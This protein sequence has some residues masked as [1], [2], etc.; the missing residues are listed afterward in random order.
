[1]GD[2]TYNLAEWLRTTQ[3]VELALWIGTTKANAALVSQFWAIPIIQV[4]HIIALSMATGSILMI[5]AKVY[6]MAGTGISFA[7]T[8]KRYSKVIW[9][10]LLTLALTGLLMIVAEPVREL[11]NPVFWLKMIVVVLTILLIQAYLKGLARNDNG[12]PASGRGVAILI[13]VC[14][15]IMIFCGRWIAYTPV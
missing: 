11:I 9:Y 3:L 8:Q 6:N 13:S 5:H 4:I 15:I 14:W 2:L 1:M 7:D 12:V 10:S